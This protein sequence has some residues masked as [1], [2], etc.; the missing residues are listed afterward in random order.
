[1]L[2]Q[3]LHDGVDRV[4]VALFESTKD[5]H[6][7]R[8]CVGPSVAAIAGLPRDRSIM[9]KV[10]FRLAKHHNQCVLPLTRQPVSSPCNGTGA[11]CLGWHI[12][13]D[14]GMGGK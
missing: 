7:N 4:Q 9:Q 11:D 5:G 13:R 8:L 6:Q 3:G 2:L 12:G 10:A 1:M 14:Y